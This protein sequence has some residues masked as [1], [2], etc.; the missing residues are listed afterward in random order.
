M[1]PSVGTSGDSMGRYE[2]TNEKKID[3][4]SKIIALALFRIY[5]ASKRKMFNSSIRKNIDIR[6]QHFPEIKHR[7]LKG[8][9]QYSRF[10]IL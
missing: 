6:F 2:V 10:K 8:A 7:Q 4:T 9:V 1:R 3:K 5:F